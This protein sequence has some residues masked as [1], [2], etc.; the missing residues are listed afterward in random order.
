MLL[1]ST[2]VNNGVVVV[3]KT[4]CHKGSVDDKYETGR[5]LTN[6][7]CILAKDMTIEC[8][9]AKLAYLFGKVSCKLSVGLLARKSEKND[10]EKP[11]RRTHRHSP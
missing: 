3:I 4:Q 8:L 2:A 10:D 1:L 5:A 7:G 9:Y 11:E 6:I